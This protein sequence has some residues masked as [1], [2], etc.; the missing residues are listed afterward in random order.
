MAEPV[1][2][3]DPDETKVEAC[4]APRENEP[5]GGPPVIP[6]RHMMQDS[7]AT[8]ATLVVSTKVLPDADEDIEMVA[9]A[10]TGSVIGAYILAG[11]IGRGGFGDVYRAEQTKPVRRSVAIKI[12]KPGMDSDVIV[13]RFEAE[14][15]ALA[16]MDHSGIA[17]I[18]DAGITSDGRSYFVMELVHGRPITAY[19]DA[20]QLSLR[21]R[22]EMFIKVCLAIEHAHQRGIVHRDVKPS[23]LLVSTEDGVPVPRVI[24]FGIAKA[25]EQPL[26]EFAVQT[27]TCEVLGTPRY[28]SP[29]QT[30]LMGIEVDHRTDI[31]ALGVVLFELATGETPFLRETEKLG[32]PM[33]WMTI[34][35]EQ[36]PPRPST[37][38]LKLGGQAAAV[39][40]CRG[41]AE[42]RGLSRQLSE[43]LDWIVLRCLEKDRERR[44]QSAADLARDLRSYLNHQP[45]IASRPGLV[46]RL[47]KLARRQ[48]DSVRLAVVF[49]LVL[50]AVLAGGFILLSK[51][52]HES[53]TVSHQEDMES[54][55]SL[56]A[57]Q[58]M[59]TE[60]PPNRRR[61]TLLAWLS[62]VDA[63][64]AREQQSISALQSM[65]ATQVQSLAPFDTEQAVGLERATKLVELLQ[66][67]REPDGP[68]ALVNGWLPRS[69]AIDEIRRL[70]SEAERGIAST[71]DGLIIQNR[72]HLVPVGMDPK[73]GLWE[74]AD[75]QLGLVPIRGAD[76][77]L[78]PDA[79]SGLIF[80]LVPGGTFEMGSPESESGRKRD[81]RLHTVT[82]GPFLISKYEVLNSQWRRAMETVPSDA[83]RFDLPAGGITWI[84]A[85]EFCKRF[86]CHLP[87]EA[88][89]EFA[90]RAGSAMPFSGAIDMDALGWYEENSQETPQPVGQ[91][92]PNAFGLYDMHGNALEW[93]QDL[94][95]D[96]FYSADHA[97]GPDPVFDP[98]VDPSDLEARSRPRVLRGGSFEGKASYCR[99][100][101]RYRESA[102]HNHGSFGFRPL[103]SIDIPE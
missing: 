70:W 42:V 92:A 46:Y 30:G 78:R 89:W 8:D 49:G 85:V 79:V 67:F 90:C 17:R 20:L 19:C 21:Q 6:E 34:I 75:L 68:R 56:I 77:V 91:K 98:P 28:M 41:A 36:E 87:T 29:E 3:P 18:F 4:I 60:V 45:I 32:A 100:A 55:L 88:Q 48:R 38:V 22:V 5:V 66:R 13:R 96:T 53:R 71:Y 44:Y 102:I 2:I 83:E 69:P 103:R 1:G 64:L 14:R 95:S 37:A 7:S 72:E 39:A 43:D 81:E 74:F 82:V 26:T 101:D 9:G 23:N 73:S 47:R 31:Y 62:E 65:Q 33:G 52:R 25:M 11:R 58:P 15:Q 61:E 76:G 93:C 27:Q 57:S 35:R 86:G 16:L 63:I 94:Y 80:V 51:T 40:Q 54:A 12:L 84:N 97:D 24:D 99:S 10:L 59:L 50:I